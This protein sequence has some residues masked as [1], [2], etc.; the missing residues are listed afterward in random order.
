ML[1]QEFFCCTIFTS[2]QY[3]TDYLF[4]TTC[5][6]ELSISDYICF[7]DAQV[8]LESPSGE[9]SKLYDINQLIL[10]VDHKPAGKF[11]YGE[12]SSVTSLNAPGS[13]YFMLYVCSDM[14]DPF[15]IEKGRP[16]E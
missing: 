4:H 5:I 2:H 14:A 7:L 9:K 10:N 6:R 16:A 12:G 11:Y 3:T 13:L 1:Y 15:F 8:H